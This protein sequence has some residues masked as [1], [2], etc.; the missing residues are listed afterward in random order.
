[1]DNTKAFKAQIK[2]TEEK[3]AI[4]EKSRK[5]IEGK[6]EKQRKAVLILKDVIAKMEALNDKI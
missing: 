4:L 1:M 3:L 2:S 5:D 6:V